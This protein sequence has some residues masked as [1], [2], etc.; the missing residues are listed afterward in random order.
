MATVKLMTTTG[1]GKIIDLIDA[2]SP[3]YGGIGTG[4]TGAAVGDTALTTEVETRDET[5]D[6]Q[7]SAV[8]FQ[9]ISEQAITGTHAIDE[10]GLFDASTNGV[11]LLTSTFDIVNLESGDEFKATWQMTQQDSSV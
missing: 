3:W 10:A 1:A 6:T 8:Q 4:G 9:A 2:A 5:T 11:M 7:P